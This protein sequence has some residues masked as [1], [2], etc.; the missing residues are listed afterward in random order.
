MKRKY[1]DIIRRHSIAKSDDDDESPSLSDEDDEPPIKTRRRAQSDDPPWPVQRTGAS[2]C[3][4][5]APVD[6]V[7]S[8]PARAGPVPSEDQPV[9]SAAIHP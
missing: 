1:A 2:N 7:E 3:R 5:D 4:P 9:P 6:S 8:Q